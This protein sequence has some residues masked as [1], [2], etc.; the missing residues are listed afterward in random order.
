MPASASGNFDWGDGELKPAGDQ[1]PMLSTILTELVG[2]ASG[3]PER[4][5]DMGHYTLNNKLWNYLEE[6]AKK[7]RRKGNGFGRGLFSPG[8]RARTLSARYYKDG[9]DILIRQENSNPRR[10]TPRECARIMGFPDSYKIVVSDTRAY[11]L[12]GN[13]VVVKLIRHIALKMYAEM[14]KR[15]LLDSGCFVE[16]SQSFIGNSS[17]SSSNLNF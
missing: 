11:R 7:H 3:D 8:E 12:F 16:N 14:L 10:L 4:F 15:G 13:S 6:Y 17:G 9:A 5:A 2:V 1:A